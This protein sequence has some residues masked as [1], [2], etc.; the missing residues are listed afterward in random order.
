MS[1][2]TK[3]YQKLT[4][5]SRTA[6]PEAVEK[7]RLDFKDRYQNFRR[8][9]GA[10][11]QALE[12]MAAMEQALS[13][14]EPFGMAFIRSSCTSAAVNVFRMIRKIDRLAPKKY[15]LLFER[16]DAIE[17]KVEALLSEKKGSSDSR[18]LIYLKD[19]DKDMVD[20]VGSK[21][22]NL[23]EIGKH[24]MLRVPDG[25]ALTAAAYQ[26]FIEE[27][28][29][30]AEIDRR[31]QS[32]DSGDFEA[33]HNLSTEIQQ[34]IIRSK[35][36]EDLEAAVAEAWALLE[37]Q[38]GSRITVALRSSAVGEDVAESSFAGQYRS[39]LNVSRDG[40][41]D[42]YKDVLASKYSLQAITYRLNRGFRDEDIPMCVGCLVM[43]DAAA[44]G[45]AYSRSP[46]NAHDDAVFINATWGL[47]KSVVD[48]SDACDE[49]V[50]SRENAFQVVREDIRKKERK[51]ACYPEEGV[52]R[53]D[54]TG[55]TQ[56]LPAISH[57]TARELAEISVKLETHYGSPQ[58]VEWG[59]DSGGL[60]Y[61]LQCRPLKTSEI[62]EGEASGPAG[63]EGG[64]TVLARGGVTASPGVA[65]GEAFIAE[66]GGDVLAFPEG[67]VL[68]VKAALPRW[69]SLLSRAAAVISEKGGFAGH[70]ANVAREFEVP[71]LFG[72]QRATTLLRRGDPVTVDA[73]GRRL[74]HGKVKAL[75]DQK[76]TRKNLMEGSPVHNLLKAVSAHIVPL[77]LLDPDAPEFH[78]KNCRTLH[79][80]TRF[81]HEKSVQEMFNF[82]KDHDFSERSSKQLHYNVPMHW[83]ILNLDDGFDREI[84]GKYVKLENIV[85]VPM[86]ALWRG[87]TAI[88]WEGPPAPDGKGMLS[89]MFRA[90]VNPALATGVRSKYADRNY[91]MISR[92]FCSLSS[93]MGFHFSTLETLVSERSAENYISFQFK[94]GAADMERRLM[95]V[96]FIAEIL[97]DLD[98]RVSIKKDHLSARMES[99]E[100][101]FM[102]KR[103]EIL[104]YLTLHTRQL[105]MIMTNPGQVEYYRSKL[106]SDIQSILSTCAGQDDLSLEICNAAG[107][108]NSPDSLPRAAS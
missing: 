32:T 7:L 12:A 86:R 4:R 42:A 49:F 53:M 41:F 47:P 25:F 20:A 67:A 80:I 105:D 99:R 48:G 52:C 65:F 89:V 82:G 92:H 78:P 34:L 90:T 30:Q 107:P 84:E 45:V 18:L 74:Y 75:L 31:I 64:E 57:E 56:D 106:K 87:F 22:A 6:K 91:F 83:W 51:F 26:R 70:L 21:M 33:L 15:A 2:L 71:A 8:L 50:V 77:N 29:L 19:I 44:G 16:F 93:R 58:D 73:T 76:K 85:S 66:K 72:I 102:L 40:F 28:D 62:Q 108:E 103:L 17:K 37:K 100:M 46:V 79:D 43:V 10:N 5:K 101:D 38:A 14:G 13:G 1:L 60:I 11:N 98:F 61:V 35:I 96:H 39:E 88:P 24:L 23:G 27:N 97:E 94:G 54:L 63:T 104:G 95:R 3:I 81:I 9:L 69:A 36:P 68:V 55:E 59:I